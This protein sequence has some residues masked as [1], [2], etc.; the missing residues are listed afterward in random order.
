M[1]EKSDLFFSAAIQLSV[2]ERTKLNLWT[3]YFSLT[4]SRYY[5]QYCGYTMGYISEELWFDYWQ[6]KEIIFFSKAPRQTLDSTQSPI[7]WVPRDHSLGG[8][9]AVV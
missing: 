2:I 6:E 4:T 1:F 8:M 3:T 5:R 9:A 7:Q